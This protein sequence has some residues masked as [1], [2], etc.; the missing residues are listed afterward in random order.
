MS[1][2]KLSQLAALLNERRSGFTHIGGGA[3]SVEDGV[4][5]QKIDRITINTELNDDPKAFA[6]HQWYTLTRMAFFDKNAPQEQRDLA[7]AGINK[8]FEMRAK[9]DDYWKDAARKYGDHL[10]PSHSSRWQAKLDTLESNRRLMRPLTDDEW[11]SEDIFRNSLHAYNDEQA[12]LTDLLKNFAEAMKDLGKASPVE[13]E[14]KALNNEEKEALLAEQAVDQYQEPLRRSGLPKPSV[15]RCKMIP[16]W[17]GEPDPIYSATFKYDALFDVDAV[18]DNLQNHHQV[19]W[20]EQL[21]R[22][23]KEFSEMANAAIEGGLPAADVART[24]QDHIVAPVQEGKGA[25]QNYEIGRALGDARI[26][27]SATR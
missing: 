6:E 22:K 26:G 1:Q 5:V 14:F 23:A 19:S 27:R 3:F 24:I 7:R 16:Q 13:T 2:E 8:M 25:H 20:R 15:T 4:L 17:T 10:D 21:A 11:K 18:I 9:D 12:P